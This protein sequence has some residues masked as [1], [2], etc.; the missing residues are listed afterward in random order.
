ME[1]MLQICLHLNSIY[2]ACRKYSP[3]QEAQH[4]T[5]F[6]PDSRDVEWETGMGSVNWQYGSSEAS[7]NALGGGGIYPQSVLLLKP[8]FSLVVT[9]YNFLV[10]LHSQVSSGCM[11]VCWCQSFLFC[12]PRCLLPTEWRWF[13]FP[14]LLMLVIFMILFFPHSLIPIKVSHLQW[15]G[16][17]PRIKGQSSYSWKNVGGSWCDL[18]QR[19]LPQSI[20]LGITVFLHPSSPFI[21]R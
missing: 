18:S 10:E 9:G 1:G 5:L 8:T 17:Y 20:I 16:G 19:D 6:E 11:F 13:L 12:V 4:S 3:C 7:C 15:A 14:A 21:E 2:Q